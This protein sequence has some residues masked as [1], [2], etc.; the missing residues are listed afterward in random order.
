VSASLPTTALVQIDTTVGDLEGNSEKITGAA[1]EA[2]AAG[3]ELVLFPELC[4]PG[5]PAEDLYLRTD[6]VRANAEALDS[7]V[8]DLVGATFVVGF[9]EPAGE[10]PP[11]RAIAFNAAAVISDGRVTETYRKRLLPNYG[12]FDE[13]RTFR[14][15]AGPLVFDCHGT[16]VGVTICE[17]C[18]EPQHPVAADLA[19]G[20]DLIVNLSASPYHRGKG[21]EREAIFR[22]TAIAKGVPVA[23]SNLVGGQDE[24]VFD[25]ASVAIR[26]DGNP[27][28]R[29]ARFRQE[30]LII[31]WDAEGGPDPIDGGLEE[32]YEALVLGLRDYVDK[33]GFDRV[34][35]GLS[36]GIDSAL[37]ALIACDALGPERVSLVVMPSPWSSSETQ[38]DARALGATLACETLEY[39]IEGLMEGYEATLGDDD[40]GLAAENVQA[41][42]RGNILM[43]LSNSRGWLILTTSN[44]SEASVG[45]STLYGDM[46]GGFAPIRDVPKGLV[47]DLTQWRNRD[48]NPVPRGILERPPSAELRPDQRDVDSLPEYELLDEIVRLH[49]EED[50]G[51]AEIVARGL[52]P[53]TVTRVVGLIDRAEYKRR[54]SPPGTRITTRAFGRDR[55]MPITNRYRPDPS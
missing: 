5:Y 26:A 47:Y 14:P 38:Q 16:R 39:G 11:G 46:A 23:V 41:R 33:N 35:L 40:R 45:Y 24:L 4:L 10:A 12:V 27:L 48:G 21:A 42:I 49:V 55:R 52:D 30:V 53:S 28:A 43:A 51:P 17:D 34:G 25:G 9:A 7:L 32:V 2:V 22:E 54:Q 19:P 37:V 20:S 31:D 13:H 29:A 3:A 50:L 36:G 8:P 44:K 18:W 6:F 1:R 15:G